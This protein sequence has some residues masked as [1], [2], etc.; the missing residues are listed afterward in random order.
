MSTQF[1]VMGVSGSGKSTVGQM[2]AE[3]WDVP[4]IEGDTLH[5]TTSVAKMAAGVPLDDADRFPWLDRVGEAMTTAAASGR[6]AVVSCSALKL[7][8]RDRLRATAGPHLRFA[9]L[10]LRREV[11]ETRMGERVGHYMPT[12]LLDSQ[13]RT[14]E[15]P[16]GETDVLIVDGEAPLSEITDAICRWRVELLTAG[17]TW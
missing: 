15:H 2:L 17:E 10:D 12:S 16:A 4:F 7:A 14:L 5:S 1:I 8:Y 9:M 11:L 3:R 6:G 13:L